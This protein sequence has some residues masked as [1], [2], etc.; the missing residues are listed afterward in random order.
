MMTDGWKKSSYSNGQG[1]NCVEARSDTG[2]S[3]VLMRDTQNRELGHLEM[4]ASEW[5]TLLRT[6]ARV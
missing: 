2:A 6:A 5:A 4:P 3:Q 1:G